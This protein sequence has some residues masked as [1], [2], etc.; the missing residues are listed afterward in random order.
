MAQAEEQTID[1]GA[2][3]ETEPALEIIAALNDVSDVL[4]MA[5]STVRFTGT[6]VTSLEQVD[7]LAGID[8]FSCP[9]GWLIL[10]RTP[11]GP[12]WCVAGTTASEAVASIADD[13]LRET[14]RRHLEEKQLL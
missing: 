3:M 4:S 7:E 2:G 11:R 8:V 12:H 1:M 14:V 5:G 13:G 9:R 6:K 10:F